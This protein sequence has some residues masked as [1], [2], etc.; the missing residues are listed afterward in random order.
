MLQFFGNLVEHLSCRP[1]PPIG[2]R[3]MR[4]IVSRN[5][6][7]LRDEAKKD[8]PLMDTPEDPAPPIRMPR[9]VPTL[10]IM[11]ASYLINLQNVTSVK[12]KVK[13]LLFTFFG[14]HY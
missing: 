9:V 5:S 6:K 1:S 3:R 11:V 2:H 13:R 4:I 14:Y 7:E 12:T 10:L 8:R